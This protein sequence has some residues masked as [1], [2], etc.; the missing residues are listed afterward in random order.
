MNDAHRPLLNPR[1]KCLYVPMRENSEEAN[2]K[3][4]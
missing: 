4:R 3:D 2:Y 1:F